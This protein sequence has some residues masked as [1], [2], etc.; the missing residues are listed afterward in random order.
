MKPGATHACKLTESQASGGG[1][2]NKSSKC[3]VNMMKLHEEQG[4]VQPCTR[5]GTSE[6]HLNL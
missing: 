2:L 5:L 1:H 4:K 3:T 6:P